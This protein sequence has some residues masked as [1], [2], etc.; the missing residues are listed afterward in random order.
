MQGNGLHKMRVDA[1]CLKVTSR[2]RTRRLAI[3]PSRDLPGV[4][5]AD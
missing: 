2:G 1:V 5:F 4:S 3:T